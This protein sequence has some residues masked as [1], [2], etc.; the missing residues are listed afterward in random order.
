MRVPSRVR[1]NERGRP[2]GV[3]SRST[4]MA[5]HEDEPLEQ[6]H[7]LLVLQ[8]R[9]VQGRNDLLLVGRA[10]RSGGMSSASSS[11]S[12]SSS[13]E[14]DGFFFNPDTL[15]NSKKLVSAADSNS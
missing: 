13:S 15:R 7:V 9:A 14:V 1:S 8:Q 2:C 10:Q 12:Q 5:I 4:V 3:G 6:V 11:L